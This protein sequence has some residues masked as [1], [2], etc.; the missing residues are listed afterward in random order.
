MST[1]VHFVTLGCPKNRVDSELMLGPLLEDGVHIAP[2]A[3]DA[4]VVVINT[5]GF[6]EDAKQESIDVILEAAKMRTDGELKQLVVTGCLVQRYADELRAEIPEIDVLLG[7]GAYADVAR[8]I[9]EASTGLDRIESPTFQHSATMPRANSYLPHS[10]FVKVSEGC[11]QKCTFCII[12]S[13]RGLQRSR[14][15]DDIR[16]EAETLV[17]RGVVE[18]NLVAQDLTG[19][20][21]DQNPR[22]H[23]TDVVEALSTVDGLWWLRLHYLYPRHLPARFFEALAHPK[24]A[25]Y[26]DMPLQHISDPVLKRMRRGRGRDFI[27]N[28]LDRLRAARPDAAI[29]TS[30]IVGFPGETDEDFEALCA[31]VE[32]QRFDHVGVFRFSRE[33]GTP[34]HDLDG[35]VPTEVIEARHAHLMELLREQSRQRLEKWVGQRIPV[36]VDGPSEETELL[37]AARHATMAPEVDGTIYINDGAARAGDL[38]EVEITETFDYDAVGHITQPL[39]SAPARPRPRWSRVLLEYSCGSIPQVYPILI[40]SLFC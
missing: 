28:M 12:P 38:V 1:R 7:N 10:A 20:G 15:L 33:E 5:C 21:Y 3:D 40:N 30:F 8:A 13:L 23:L 35:Q 27:E 2:S 36:L 24:V 29:R 32:A 11:D 31:F 39:R 37:L 34:S 9:R 26:I 19:Y 16:L 18:L 4:D 6:I 25:P 17:S 22:V 14:P